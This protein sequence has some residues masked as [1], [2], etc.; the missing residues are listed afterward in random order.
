MSALDDIWRRAQ[1]FVGR[2]ASLLDARRWDEWLDLYAPDCEYWVPAWGDDGELTSDPRSQ[3]SMI[4]YDNRGGLEDRVFRIRTGSS[5]AST[6]A[7]RTNHLFS[8]VNCET[9]ATGLLIETNWLTESFREDQRL[10][11]RGQ[12][13]YQL[14]ERDG[15]LQIASKRT[16]VLDPLTDTVLD[17]YTI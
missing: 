15:R 13:T 10:S 8:I 12:A 14:T 3:I 17:F 4:Y 1:A 9:T 2:E 5:S 16:V 7:L 11:Y 6:P